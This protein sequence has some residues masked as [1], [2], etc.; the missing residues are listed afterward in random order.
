MN[1]QLHI[2]KKEQ[3]KP[4]V[5]NSTQ[6]TYN[7]SNMGVTAAIPIEPHHNLLLN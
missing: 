6:T 2:E 1:F 7:L 4:Y 3:F 5:Y